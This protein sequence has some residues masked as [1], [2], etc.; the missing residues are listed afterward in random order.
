MSEWKCPACK[1]TPHDR[2]IVIKDRNGD[3]WIAWAL[4]PDVRTGAIRYQVRGKPVVQ[5]TEI[6][7]WMD[8]P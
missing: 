3:F 1:P 4:L 6:V 7:G 8:L 5:E 2:K